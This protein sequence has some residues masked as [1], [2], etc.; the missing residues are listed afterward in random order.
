MTKIFLFF[1][2]SISILFSCTQDKTSTNSPNIIYILA[3]DLG[4]GYLG[5]YGQQKIETPNI[6]A[7]A[8]SGMRFTQHY[9]G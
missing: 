7:L 1:L 3:D 4:Y 5:V 8:E 9:S 6:D 2:L